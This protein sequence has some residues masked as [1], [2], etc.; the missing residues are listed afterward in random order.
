L[1]VPVERDNIAKNLTAV[2]RTELH[3]ILRGLESCHNARS[4]RKARLPN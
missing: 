4:C 2:Q 3:K 1:C